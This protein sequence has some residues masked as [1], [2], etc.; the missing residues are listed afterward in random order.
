MLDSSG[1]FVWFPDARCGFAIGRIV[2][3]GQANV[4]VQPVAWPSVAS[5]NYEIDCPNNFQNN[6]NNNKQETLE[7]PYKSVYPCDQFQDD[8][9]QKHQRAKSTTSGQYQDKHI[10]Y[11]MDDSCALIQLNEAALLENV[12]VRFHRDKIY[13]YVAHILI[14]VNPYFEINGLHSSEAIAKYQGKSLGTMPPHVYA[15]GKHTSFLPSLKVNIVKHKGLVTMLCLSSGYFTIN[16][17]HSSNIRF[18]LTIL[19]LHS[20]KTLKLY[21]RPI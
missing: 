3:I 1:K 14:A 5:V 8:S 18:Y 15:I 12:R 2:D 19:E 4:T 11:D 20:Y 21:D 17:A 6:N 16:F 9:N 7:F 10:G 13:T